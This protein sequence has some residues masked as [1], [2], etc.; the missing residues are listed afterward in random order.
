MFSPAGLRSSFLPVPATPLGWSQGL[1]GRFYSNDCLGQPHSIKL[2]YIYLPETSFLAMLSGRTQHHW[3]CP[4]I[5]FIA[6]G[7][8]MHESAV[9]CVRPRDARENRPHFRSYGRPSDLIK[10]TG[11]GCLQLLFLTIDGSH[12]PLPHGSPQ[13]SKG[14]DLA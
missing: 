8:Q 6:L 4:G 1:Q 5:L 3:M 7:P 10:Q 2:F 14:L 12:T 9:L 13:H 11:T